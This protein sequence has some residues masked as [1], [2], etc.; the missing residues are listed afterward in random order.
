MVNPSR[1]LFMRGAGFYFSL[2]LKIAM[3][4]TPQSV[5][6]YIRLTQKELGL[7]DVSISWIDNPKYRGL[8][9]AEQ[10][11][12][13]LSLNCLISFRCF[14][15]TLIHELLHLADYR[16]RKGYL[17]NK[18]EMAHGKNWRKLCK[19]AGIPARKKIPA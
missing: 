11:R 13:E 6:Q 9:Y 16:Q 4:L 18:Y 1:V 3:N 5:S 17:V 15:E 2:Y 8:A 7:T 19:Q 14:R 12:I 10:N